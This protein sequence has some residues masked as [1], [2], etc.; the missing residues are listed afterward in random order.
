MWRMD[1]MVQRARPGYPLAE[2][3]RYVYDIWL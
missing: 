1:A 3:V 2:T